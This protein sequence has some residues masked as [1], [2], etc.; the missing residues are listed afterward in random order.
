[1]Q[2]TRRAERG[3]NHEV[4]DARQGREQRRRGLPE[5]LPRRD[6]GARRAGAPRRRGHDG[7]PGEPARRGD[8]GGHR[9][10]HRGPR[11]R[12]LSHGAAE[13]VTREPGAWQ[14]MIRRHAS[15]GR[16]LRRVH[17]V[18]EPVSDYVRFEM[19]WA[20][21]VNVAAGEQVR[22]IAVR[23]GEWPAA[24]PREDFWLLDDTELWAMRYDD[25][26][27]FLHAEHLDDRGAVAE[28]AAAARTAYAAAV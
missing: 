4:A 9:R 19:A 13:A 22:V 18:R 10:R 20:Y 16:R 5:R 15:S 8:G 14:A 27:R 12:G 24:V 1:M 2:R 11:H 17:V 25:T 23:G 21:P 26:G 6:R 7:A 28:H 3:T